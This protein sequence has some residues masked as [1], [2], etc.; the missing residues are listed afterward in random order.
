[1]SNEKGNTP[2][3]PASGEVFAKPKRRTFTREY[4][5]RI[6]REAAQAREIG[7]VGALLRREGLYSS[8]L[9]EWRREFEDGAASAAAL[10]PRRRGPKPRLS[11]QE[12]AMHKMQRENERLR[13]KLALT[14]AL[15]DLQKKTLAMLETL[16][17]KEG[18]E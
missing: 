14:E 1:M 9:V 8:A 15:L 16:E 10:E 18:G 12:K 11:P 4:K 3:S 5:L 2:A 17:P 7:G 13:K 6:V